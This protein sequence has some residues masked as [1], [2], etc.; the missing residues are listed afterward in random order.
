M[1]VVKYADFVIVITSENGRSW[2]IYIFLDVGLIF[3]LFLPLW[4][5][6]GV[7]YSVETPGRLC[8]APL[9]VVNALAVTDGGDQD[10]VELQLLVAH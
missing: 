6:K 5:E 3:L 9:L 2:T 4:S 7:I 1:T 10:V 8:G